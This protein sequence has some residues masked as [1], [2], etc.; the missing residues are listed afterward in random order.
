[1]C[2]TITPE[3]IISPTLRRYHTESA[4]LLSELLN[5]RKISFQQ[6]QDAT[7]PITVALVMGGNVDVIYT[8]QV[9]SL[10]ESE[11]DIVNTQADFLPSNFLFQSPSA[12]FNPGSSTEYSIDFSL[13]RVDN[14][15]LLRLL[16]EKRGQA[17]IKVTMQMIE[18][19]H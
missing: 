4:S 12:V 8:S 10:W 19:P 5:E 17:Q 13:D 14:E 3:E 18:I 1:M 2:R 11:E 16:Q 7:F 9:I 6:Y 15:A